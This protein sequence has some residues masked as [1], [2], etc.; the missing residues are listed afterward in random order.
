MGLKG[1]SGGNSQSGGQDETEDVA[2]DVKAWC[3]ELGKES[4]SQIQG[5][6]GYC[7]KWNGS[8]WSRKGEAISWGEVLGG[9]SRENSILV[10]IF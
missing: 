8:A 1:A 2:L 5:R 10:K 6:I 7:E 4:R 3:R 9:E